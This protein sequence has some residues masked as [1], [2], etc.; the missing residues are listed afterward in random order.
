M[1][2][3][4]HTRRYIPD[5]TYLSPKLRQR[6]TDD[7]LKLV[8]ALGYDMNTVEWALRDG[9]P[10]AIDFMNPAPDM[11]VNSLTPV[12]FEWAVSHM[13]SMAIRLAT[14]PRPRF[15]ARWDVLLKRRVR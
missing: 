8:R 15:E 5:E 7:S 1:P 2:Y 4:P 3:D 13:A 9:V 10:Y 11:D 14:E 6:V 12:Y